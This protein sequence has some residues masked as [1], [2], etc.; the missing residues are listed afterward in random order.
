[1]SENTRKNTFQELNRWSSL[2][3]KVDCI[4]QM[5]HQNTIRT[6]QEPQCINGKGWTVWIRIQKL[7]SDLKE[8]L[9]EH[10]NKR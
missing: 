9:I 7:V 8:K 4:V 1:M 5:H 2:N 6:T 3:V 10:S